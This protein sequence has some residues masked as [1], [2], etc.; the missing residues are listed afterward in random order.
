M[1]LRIV[2]QGGPSLYDGRVWDDVD[3]DDAG[4]VLLPPPGGSGPDAWY[5]VDLDEVP[6]YSKA[7]STRRA[8]Y[9]AEYLPA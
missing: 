5:R 6:V 8:R 9:V 3:A 4:Y 7:G 2:C 1:K